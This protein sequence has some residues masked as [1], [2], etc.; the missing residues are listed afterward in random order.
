MYVNTVVRFLDMICQI[1]ENAIAISTCDGEI[2]YREYRNSARAIGTYLISVINEVNN[3]VAV[4]MPKGGQALKTYMG[5]LYSGN[6][7][8]PIP[9]GSPSERAKQM[10]SALEIPYLLTTYSEL[11]VVDGWGVSRDKVIIL[12]NIDDETGDE[13]LIEKTLARII[14]C[15]PAYLLFTSG[16][17]NMPKGVV[18]S[19]RA[20]IDRV[21]WMKNEF[22]IAC[23]TVLGNQAPFHFDASMPD[24]FLNIVAG[25]RLVIPPD[26]IFSFVPELLVFL[27]E[28][29]VNTLIWVPSAL[30]NLTYKNAVKKYVL[31]QLKLVIFCGEV[32]HNKYLNILRGVYPDVMFVNMYGP[33]EAAYACTYYIVDRAFEDSESLPIGKPCGNTDIILKSEKGETVEAHNENG[34]ICIRGSSVAL[35]YYK[36]QTDQGFSFVDYSSSYYNMMYHTGDIGYWN[37]RDELMYVG[38]CDGQIKHMGYRIELGE[39]ETAV[40]SI[41]RINH[42]CALYDDKG[43]RIVLFYDSDDDR[44][45]RK[46]IINGLCDLIPQYMHPKVIYR[47]DHLPF[48]IN[49]KIDRKKLKEYIDG[50]IYEREN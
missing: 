49:G 44:C 38:R 3:P 18:V 2:T 34:E 28:K 16:S 24:I 1:N 10:L 9:Y 50:G 4:Y 46:Y 31:D 8:C 30:A 37:E 43:N 11:K 5:I 26:K 48:N 23:E 42:A 41:A 22:S 6:Y 17:T 47:M 32:M 27:Q 39:I 21:T 25:A 13:K 19:H 14:D 36:N 35:G 40:L 29:K 45:D 7:Y 15:D 20:I 12:D 33:T